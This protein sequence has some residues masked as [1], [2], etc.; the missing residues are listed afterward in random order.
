MYEKPNFSIK[1][2]TDSDVPAIAARWEAQYKDK[3]S[4]EWKYGRK[5]LSSSTL[6]AVEIEIGNSSWTTITC[7][8]CG[9]YVRKAVQFS[10]YDTVQSICANC[11]SIIGALGKAINK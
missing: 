6:D 3:N 1:I 11:A 4:G 9:S 7:D 2:M 8:A 5:P 10:D